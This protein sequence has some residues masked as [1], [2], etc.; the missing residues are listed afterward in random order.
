[1]K[2]P[3]TWT[4]RIMHIAPNIVIL[5]SAFSLTMNMISSVNSSRGLVLAL[6]FTGFIFASILVKSIPYKY[7]LAAIAYLAFFNA[8]PELSFDKLVS[9]MYLSLVLLAFLLPSSLPTFFAAGFYLYI[10][11]IYWSEEPVEMIRTMMV[12]VIVNMILYSLL[13]FY[14]RNLKEENSINVELNLQLNQAFGELENIAYYDT[15]TKLPNRELLK[16]RMDTELSKETPL[17][18]MF[19]D[20]DH[21]KNVNDMMGH[22]AGDQMLQDVA[23]RLNETVGHSCF[24]SRYSGDEFILLLSYKQQEEIET[25]AERLIR[26]FRNPFWIY[27]KQFYTTPSIGISLY[28]EDAHDAETLIQ[29]ADKAMYSVKRSEKNGFRFFSAI[30]STELLRQ[31]KLENDL[32]SAVSKGEII[33]HYQPLVE[34][35]TGRIRGWRR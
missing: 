17:A 19:L 29:Y 7:V 14:F 18:V 6:S 28:P 35:S 22:N 2:L 10:T 8:L 24:I 3:K 25:L 27:Q 21:F 34:I 11:P 15:L 9:V 1:M 4:K 33:V 12:G 26:S 20:L 5:L 23:R 31:V 32:R 30:R 16:E 13:A